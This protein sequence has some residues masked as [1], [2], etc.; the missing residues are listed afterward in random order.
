MFFFLIL[1]GCIN[2]NTQVPNL[3]EYPLPELEVKQPVMIRNSALK[4]GEIT[5]GRIQ[6][7]RVYG[8]LY[9]FTESA[10][11][12]ATII[13]E[14]NHIKVQSGA[15]KILELSV[16]D[17][18]SELDETF[19]ETISLRVRTGAGLTREYS[20]MQNHYVLYSASSA[21]ENAIAQCAL[22][23]LSDPDI[24]NYLENNIEEEGYYSPQNSIDSFDEDKNEYYS[25]ADQQRK[26]DLKEQKNE[27][28]SFD[29][30]ADEY[31][32]PGK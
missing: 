20:I 17:A 24:V 19:K 8:D 5:I 30:D 27:V 11:G 22:K 26:K 32:S 23:M 12:A 10:V 29:A 9:Q 6:A 14:S 18:K 15:D 25:P 2:T 3:S 31:Y 1:S 4:S 7:W 13:L 21:I 16:Y 28:D